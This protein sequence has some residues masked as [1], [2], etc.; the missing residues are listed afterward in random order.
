MS[1]GVDL[2]ISFGSF[3]LTIVIALCIRI[4]FRRGRDVGDL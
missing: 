2:F 1:S 4:C 3:L